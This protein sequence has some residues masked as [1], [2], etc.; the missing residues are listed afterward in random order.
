VRADTRIFLR[1]ITRSRERALL[2]DDRAA[3]ATEFDAIMALMEDSALH[4]Q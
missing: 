4:R 2:A 1:V 3:I